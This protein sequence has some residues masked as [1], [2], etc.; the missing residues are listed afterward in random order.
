MN[1]P[2]RWVV[3]TFV[4]V[5]GYRS[6]GWRRP[7]CSPRARGVDV[8]VEP[9]EVVRVIGRFDTGQAVVIDAVGVPNP[10]AALL[11]EVVDVHAVEV[12]AHGI[13]ELAG[14]SHVG[15]RV[16]GVVPLG[17][18]QKVVEAAAMREG[19]RSRCDAAGGARDLLQADP[20]V[21]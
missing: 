12:R 19:G 10:V 20:G 1:S 4:P 8:L 21:R 9:E 14:P 5:S 18:D 2:R 15:W 16:G 6:P 11:T 3:A 7:S 17:Q 13:E